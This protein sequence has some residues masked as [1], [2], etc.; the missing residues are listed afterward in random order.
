MPL[1]STLL[2]MSGDALSKRESVLPLVVTI[3]T[4]DAFDVVNASSSR[5]R[6]NAKRRRLLAG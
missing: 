2:T 4:A 6:R 5:E 3:R 1:I